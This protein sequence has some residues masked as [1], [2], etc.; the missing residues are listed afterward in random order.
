LVPKESTSPWCSG[1]SPDRPA[2]GSD[3]DLLIV[4]SIGLR[5]V[6]RRLTPAQDVLAREIN[7]VVWTRKEL[8]RRRKEKDAFLKRVLTGPTILVTGEA[9]GG[10]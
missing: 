6:V 5:E 2:A 7:P 8:E 4:G 1:P 3:V 9:P 10:E